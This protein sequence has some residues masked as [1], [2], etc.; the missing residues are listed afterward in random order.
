MFV[1]K[2][3]LW[4]ALCP[5][6]VAVVHE[7]PAQ[8]HLQVEVIQIEVDGNEVTLELIV[9]DRIGQVAFHIDV[10]VVA[11]KFKADGRT[12]ETTRMDHQFGACLQ[13]LA[14]SQREIR[15]DGYGGLQRNVESQ[16]H[17]GIFLCIETETCIK[18]Y[19]LAVAGRKDDAH[20][21][22]YSRRFVAY[23]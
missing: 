5:K 11:V 19:R 1:L 2:R 4:R 20:A 9:E 3:H 13:A 23:P 14:Q 6:L 15:T 18:L 8:P 17:S 7:V 21:V 12:C 16:L 10:N 22:T